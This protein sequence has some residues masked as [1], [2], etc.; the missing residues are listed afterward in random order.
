M[1]LLQPRIEGSWE[2]CNQKDCDMIFFRY[3]FGHKCYSVSDKIGT[4]PL[5]IFTRKTQNGTLP[6][7]NSDISQFV[8]HKSNDAKPGADTL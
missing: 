8:H 5:C 7:K 1:S 2:E 4:C 3:P 6:K